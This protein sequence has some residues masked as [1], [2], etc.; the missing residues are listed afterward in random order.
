M[1]TIVNLDELLPEDI[2]VT[3]RGKDYPLPGD[4]DVESVF[5]LFAIF[6][7]LTTQP[8]DGK[9]EEMMEQIKSRFGDVNAELLALFRE[10]QPDLEKLPFGI[11]GTGAVIKLILGQLGLSISNTGDPTPPPRT[12]KKTTAR[13][14]SNRKRM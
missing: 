5:R 7:A 2:V 8:I 12:A 13:R 3:Y 6:T 9:P 4:I 10:R 1:A 14:A 11:A